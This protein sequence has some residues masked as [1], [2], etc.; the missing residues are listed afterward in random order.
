M[1]YGWKPPEQ[2]RMWAG[3]HIREIPDPVPY[4]MQVIKHPHISRVL[5]N[6][7]SDIFSGNSPI[8]ENLKK[9]I[10][11]EPRG[12]SKTIILASKGQGKASVPREPN[13]WSSCIDYFGNYLKTEVAS[14]WLDPYQNDQNSWPWADAV[15]AS[16]MEAFEKRPE[17]LNFQ[18]AALKPVL[19]TEVSDRAN[20]EALFSEFA[21]DLQKIRGFGF[22]AEARWR[23]DVKKNGPNRA[24]K[25]Y[26]HMLSECYFDVTGLK[27]LLALH[28]T[29]NA[30]L[31]PQFIR[32]DLDKLLPRYSKAFVFSS[33]LTIVRGRRS[34]DEFLDKMTEAF[35]TCIKRAR[36][37]A[38][39]LTERPEQKTQVPSR[40]I[41]KRESTGILFDGISNW[42]D[43]EIV[44]T[45]EERVQINI[46]G[47]YLETRNYAEMGFEDRR[48]GKPNKSWLILRVMAE[49]EGLL[50]VTKRASLKTKLS[51]TEDRESEELEQ[52]KSA[53]YQQ[54]KL[55]K[56]IQEIRSVLRVKF[57]ISADPLPHAPTLGYQARFKIRCAPAYEV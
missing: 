18:V 41:Q 47:R 45:S 33:D 3:S 46:K 12:P 49:H 8:W 44:F 29:E 51:Q 21:Q 30:S 1:P 22:I 35:I 7:H 23:E 24:F 15:A 13:S 14:D 42:E 17:W 54:S 4:F 52:R 16:I 56:R 40:S 6:I 55:E 48:N 32:E 37:R 27:A 57:G 43:I 19:P 20:S 36:H 34:M 50:K 10:L 5:R 31:D 39:V 26:E 53:G 28:L 2:A 11:T 38:S 25:D 9:A